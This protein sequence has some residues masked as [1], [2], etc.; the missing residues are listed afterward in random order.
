[1]ATFEMFRAKTVKV[2]R[3]DNSVGQH[4]PRDGREFRTIQPPFD[5]VSTTGAHLAHVDAEIA[6]RHLRAGRHR[7]HH[8][9]LQMHFDAADGFIRLRR[10]RKFSGLH[11]R[12]AENFGCDSRNG[13][14][15][16][17]GVDQ[18]NSRGSDVS[19]IA[20][21]FGDLRAH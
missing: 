11:H 12:V 2:D 6:D 10:F 1:M 3:L 13:G 4:S 19:D 9:G 18:I 20:A 8:P 5:E 21:Q 16:R 15:I 7:V 14:S 17:R